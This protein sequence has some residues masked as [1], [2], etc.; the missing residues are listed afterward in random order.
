MAG[1]G[2]CKGIVGVVEY[3]CGS[4]WRRRYATGS[5]GEAGSPVTVVSLPARRAG[6]EGV[7]KSL[8]APQLHGHDGAGR[9]H[10]AAPSPASRTVASLVE[11]ASGP[12]SA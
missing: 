1:I 11:L 9:W 7:K 4:P 2:R 3:D 10:A 5:Q 12:G 6:L 8:P